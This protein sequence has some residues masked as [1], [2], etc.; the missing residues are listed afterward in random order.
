MKTEFT[1]IISNGG[2]S[3]DVPLTL[4]EQTRVIVTVAE[5]KQ[6]DADSQTAKQLELAL[7]PKTK[8][9]RIAAMKEFLEISSR[10]RIPLS[11]LKFTRDELYERD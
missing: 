3:F 1:G 2:V 4:P 5:P 8:E 6:L 10:T 7:A 9:Q 11:D